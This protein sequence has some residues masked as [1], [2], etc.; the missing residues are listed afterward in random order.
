MSKKRENLSMQDGVVSWNWLNRRW[1]LWIRQVL[2]GSWLMRMPRVT[3]LAAFVWRRLLRRTTFVAIT[4]SLGKTTCKE[5]TAAILQAQAPTFWTIG[6]QNSSQFVAL[7]ILRVRP[8]H[9]YAVL[10]VASAAPGMMPRIA[11]VVRPDIAVVLAIRRTHSTQFASLD[12]HAREKEH[13]LRAASPRGTIVL[14][15][16]DPRVTAMSGAGTQRIVRFGISEASHVRARK[17]AAPWPERLTFEVTHESRTL[18]VKTQLVGEHWLPSVLGALATALVVG[19]PLDAAVRSVGSVPP[20]R[21]RLQPIRLP[22]GAVVL[23]DDYNASLDGATAAFQVMRQARARRR[24][25][26]FSDLSDFGGNRKKRLRHVAALLPEIAEIAIFAG[27]DFEY[28]VRR[29][30]ETGLRPDCVF[31]FATLRETAEFLRTQMGEGDL[32]LLKGRTTDHVARIFFAQFGT[33][34]CWKIRCPKTML[35]D[36]C[37]ELGVSSEDLR[38]VSLVPP[39]CDGRV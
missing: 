17:I 5:L 16:D 38:R 21:G 30:I 27:E 15:D 20:F 29:S 37:W 9:R 19:V 35:C 7:N 2:I 4:G 26:V 18:S 23:R 12:Q 31:G 24:I 13:L 14:F 8:W 11:S 39:V 3:M 32:V 6:N 25:L 28:A 10:E 22:N 33:V 1:E 34:S 36:E